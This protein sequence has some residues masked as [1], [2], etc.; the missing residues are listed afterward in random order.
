VIA[1][2]VTRAAGWQEIK[3]DGSILPASRKCGLRFR[4]KLR[5]FAAPGDRSRENL[6]RVLR[7]DSANPGVAGVG[8]SGERDLAIIDDFDG[9]AKRLRELKTPSPKSADE[10]A[11]LEKWR[12]LARETARAYVENRRRGVLDHPP[13]G[14]RRS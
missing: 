5:P 13:A 2:K 12:D 4:G 6:P 7:S 11:E 3:P 8:V 9:I 1:E 10:I 14:Q